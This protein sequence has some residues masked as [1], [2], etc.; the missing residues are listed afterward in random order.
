VFDTSDV[1]MW[2]Q[3]VSGMLKWD[4]VS[5]DPPTALLDRCADEL[6]SFIALANKYV[7]LTTWEEILYDLKLK[8]DVI[9]VMER[10]RTARSVVVAVRVA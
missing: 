4:V 5:V 9:K 8:Y 6:P 7:I 3:N 2:V 10:S 1:F